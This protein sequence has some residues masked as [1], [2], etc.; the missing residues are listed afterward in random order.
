MHC[1]H[2]LLN[3]LKQKC[4]NISS[5]PK[6]V[7]KLK[8]L[9]KTSASLVVH[10]EKCRNVSCNMYSFCCKLFTWS[11]LKMHQSPCVFS[12]FVAFSAQMSLITLIFW[13]FVWVR[14]GVSCQ[15]SLGSWPVVDSAVRVMCLPENYKNLLHAAGNELG[16]LLRSSSAFTDVEWFLHK[17]DF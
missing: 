10:Q 13:C 14:I 2:A 11:M 4:I 1:T 16:A 17:M 12:S 7:P 3:L 5:D 8:I 6:T 15:K 9:I